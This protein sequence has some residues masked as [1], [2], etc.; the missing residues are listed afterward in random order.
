MIK[1]SLHATCRQRSRATQ[2]IKEQAVVVRV[3]DGRLTPVARSAKALARVARRSVRVQHGHAEGGTQPS[4]HGRFNNARNNGEE[5]REK[6]GEEEKG[7]GRSKSPR[8]SNSSSRR[9]SRA[10]SAIYD[11]RAATVPHDCTAAELF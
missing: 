6:G 3:I 10:P 2:D 1:N 5:E 4:K 8:L 11:V 9:A 7:E